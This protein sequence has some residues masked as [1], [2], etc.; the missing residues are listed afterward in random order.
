VIRYLQFLKKSQRPA[1]ARGDGEMRN[2]LRRA[3]LVVVLLTLSLSLSFPASMGKGEAREMKD[4]VAFPDTTKYYDWCAGTNSSGTILV[5]VP[6]GATWEQMM[7]LLGIESYSPWLLIQWS[8][9]TGR[10]R[11]TDPIG[12]SILRACYYVA[13]DMPIYDSCFTPSGEL[14]VCRVGEDWTTVRPAVKWFNIVRN[15]GQHG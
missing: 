7:R 14:A 9:V 6:E 10:I 4:W 3:V 12:T 8:G 11:T 2:L 1:W 13:Y 15:L 5:E